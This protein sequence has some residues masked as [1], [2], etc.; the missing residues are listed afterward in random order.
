MFTPG[1]QTAR[2]KYCR[3]QGSAS[4]IGMRAQL[5]CNVAFIIQHRQAAQSTPVRCMTTLA[6]AE[7]RKHRHASFARPTKQASSVL[8]G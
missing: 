7:T 6:Q 8:E 5:D 3:R 4:Q 1:G 2:S